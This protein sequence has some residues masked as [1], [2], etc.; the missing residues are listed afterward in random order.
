MHPPSARAEDPPGA[1]S[2]IH[3][4]GGLGS[5]EASAGLSFYFSWISSLDMLY[6]SQDFYLPEK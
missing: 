5:D 4:S 3:T 6:L 1:L 2:T